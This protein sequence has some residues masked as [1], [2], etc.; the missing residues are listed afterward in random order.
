[1]H[2]VIG[3]TVS[4]SLTIL[5]CR[6]L[7]PVARDYV[8]GMWEMLQQQEPEDFVLATGETHPVREFVEKAFSHVDI[9]IKCV[10]P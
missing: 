8:E 6:D 10:L 2:N 3:D 5:G 4:M 9:K 1:M 7:F